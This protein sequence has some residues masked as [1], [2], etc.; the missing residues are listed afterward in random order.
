MPL[1]MQAKILRVLA[2]NKIERV[3]GKKSIH[4]NIRVIVA[5]NRDLVK[6]IKENR[7]RED[8]FY[9][10]K[11]FRIKLPPLR[12]RKQEIYELVPVFVQQF[13]S[14]LNKRV[15]KISDEYYDFLMNYSWPGNIRELRNAVQYSIVTLDGSIL[16][17]KHLQG[18]FTHTSKQVQRDEMLW[19]KNPPFPSKLSD[20][21]RNAIRKSLL[22][23]KGNKL[24]AAKLLG[25]GRATLHR[26]LKG[27]D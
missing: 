13:S 19:V 25:I 3:G 27:M 4:I 6:E 9:R 1:N 11:V 5:T 17:D 26:K 2:E 15:E 12:E 14:F 7:F 16:L 20:L 23:T 24:K 21:E 8:L 10:L 22:L 18:F